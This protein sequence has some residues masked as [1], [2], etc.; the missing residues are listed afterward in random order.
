MLRRD[1]FFLTGISIDI[2]VLSSRTNTNTYGIA[3]CQKKRYNVIFHRK[4][5]HCTNTNIDTFELTILINCNR[6]WMEVDDDFT[7]Y[8]QIIGDARNV[9]NGF[10]AIS[11]FLCENQ[12]STWWSMG[13]DQL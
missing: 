5:V 9:L 12:R 3:I 1:F 2:Y 6:I 4:I 8:N 7:H 11:F 10:R 13:T